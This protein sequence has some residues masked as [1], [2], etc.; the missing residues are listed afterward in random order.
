[1]LR[2]SVARPRHSCRKS[3][4]GGLWST[5]NPW[6]LGLNPRTEPPPIHTLLTKISLHFPCN[7]QR[8]QQRA[9][10]WHLR[11]H[12]GVHMRFQCEKNTWLSFYETYISSSDTRKIQKC[13]KYQYLPMLPPRACMTR[14]VVPAGLTLPSM[15]AVWK[16]GNA[17]QAVATQRVASGNDSRDS[18]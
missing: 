3:K 18:P 1:M 6:W 9:S 7:T 16:K 17:V 12:Y 15:I 8:R 2:F 11:F 5:G 10:R 4:T 14:R 13:S